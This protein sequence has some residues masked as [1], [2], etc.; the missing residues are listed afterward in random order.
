[1]AELGYLTNVSL[2]GYIEDEHGALEWS[3]SVG[4]PRPGAVYG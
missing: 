3:R 1:M 4:L 2:A